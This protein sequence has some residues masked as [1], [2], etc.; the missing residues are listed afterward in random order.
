MGDQNPF[1][2]VEAEKLGVEELPLVFDD[3][4]PGKITLEKIGMLFED[5]TFVAE[6]DSDTS[7]SSLNV[8]V[9]KPLQT[10]VKFN[11]AVSRIAF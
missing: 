2:K 1:Q 10:E 3:S 8:N 9:D 5:Y 7:L 11:I 6:E 4:A